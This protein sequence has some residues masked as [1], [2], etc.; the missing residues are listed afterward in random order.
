MTLKAARGKH[1]QELIYV[2]CMITAEYIRTVGIVYNVSCFLLHISDDCK[3]FNNIFFL[4]SRNN[5]GTLFA[6]MPSVNKYN[7]P[8]ELNVLS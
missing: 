2:I 1:E 4:I 7:K 6:D 8:F 5:T 3:K